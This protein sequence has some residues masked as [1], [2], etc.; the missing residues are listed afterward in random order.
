MKKIS[1]ILA[2]LILVLL[3]FSGCKNFV[4]QNV[5][6]KKGYVYFNIKDA[7]NS[8]A[9]IATASYDWNNFTYRLYAKVGGSSERKVIVPKDNSYATK[10]EIFTGHELALTSYVFT[11]EAYD[12]NKSLVFQSADVP[13]DLSNG[14]STVSFI[15]YPAGTKTGSALITL[16]FP[17]GEDVKSVSCCT[18][19][20]KTNA[21]S[22]KK[23]VSV[24]STSG[25]YNVVEY[26]I[27]DLTPGYDTVAV[28][29]LNDVNGTCIAS[30]ME[31]LVIVGGLQSTSEIVLSANDYRKYDVQM[32]LKLEGN[33]WGDSKKQLILVPQEDINDPN[34]RT[35]FLSEVKATATFT[36]NIAD[37]PYYIYVKDLS[38]NK[39]DDQPAYGYNTMVEY[40]P[41]VNGLIS[42]YEMN[43]VTL[44]AR[45]LNYNYV[46]GGI[47][48]GQDSDGNDMYYVAK[49]QSLTVGINI[50]EGYSNTSVNIEGKSYQNNSNV[51]IGP[52]TSSK[53]VSVLGVS[54]Q[55]YN[56][57]Y[58]MG[59]GSQKDTSKFKTS[60]TVEDTVDL[61]GIAAVQGPVENK[62]LDGWIDAQ[63]N[64]L[65]TIS[66]GTTG[67]KLFTA[68]YKTI[69]I[70]LTNNPS[71]KLPDD[72]EAGSFD[73]F[74]IYPSICASGFSMIVKWQNDDPSTNV[75]EVW[76]DMNG[77]GA[78]DVDDGDYRVTGSANPKTEDFTGYILK[79]EKPNSSDKP[80][81]NFTFSI[82]GGH[83][84]AIEGLGAD[85]ANIS[86]VNI[87]GTNT[88]I[89]GTVKG[90]KTGVN[91]PTF[92]NE[93]INIAGQL[94]GEYELTILSKNSYYSR[95][96]FIDV[97]KIDDKTWVELGKVTC[98]YVGTD[99][100]KVEFEKEIELELRD[101]T[102]N[103]T[104]YLYIRNPE[105]I[106][107]PSEELS[108]PGENVPGG[109]LWITEPDGNISKTEFTLGDTTV[110]NKAC[111]VFSILVENGSMKLS[112]TQM[113][114]NAGAYIST[115][116]LGKYKTKVNNQSYTENL[117]TTDTYTYIHMMSEEN[118]LTPFS[119]TEFLK[120]IHFIKNSESAKIKIKLNLEAVDYAD[121]AAMVQEATANTGNSKAF[122][123][124]DGSFYLGVRSTAT[125]G[126]CTW[127]EAYNGAKQIVFNGMRGYLINITSDVENDYIFNR[128]GLGKAWT[129]GARYD[130]VEDHNND[131]SFKCHLDETYH[132]V[133]DS[134]SRTSP[135]TA[136]RIDT[137]HYRWQCGPEAGN[138]I[139]TGTIPYNTAAISV[140]EPTKITSAKYGSSYSGYANKTVD[141]LDA[142]KVKIGTAVTGTSGGSMTKGY[143]L[144]ITSSNYTGEPKYIGYCTTGTGSYTGK[145]NIMYANWAS[146]EPNDSFAS[147]TSEEC[148]H[149][150]T[151]GK[152]ND[153]NWDR[154]GGD[155]TV[156]SYIVEF[157]PYETVYGKSK[158]TKGSIKQEASY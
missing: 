69:E 81:S 9:R 86:T 35:I 27:S 14:T 158:A 54:C 33:Q 80:A 61:P 149:F 40:Q 142:N 60:Y 154:Y 45:G 101:D 13:V 32:P 2:G 20:I 92:K 134:P 114:N 15:M 136:F 117:T 8:G 76:L 115:S 39:L 99:T 55:I 12:S 111:S 49:N 140:F 26:A 151:D 112:E 106:G 144:T 7:D 58:D 156:T 78:I 145:K 10:S 127:I 24:F 34:P 105:E 135:G 28:F 41:S 75:T 47:Y 91:L 18:Q 79:A 102:R 46:S 16:K 29:Y 157:S 123:Y 17:K 6:A 38:D 64:R 82:Y 122:S 95:K 131:G 125:N 129:G 148:I 30:R 93:C 108:V 110:I 72:A 109:V 51:V 56:I 141:L 52:V 128:M 19:N 150:K 133:Y 90:R 31:S 126:G 118:S 1:S 103:N 63:G 71:E 152:W 65:S 121:I 59:G 53:M 139:S 100:S 130:S 5:D 84:A 124:Y 50:K 57:R 37:I 73:D 68:C 137:P 42:N 116:N 94:S 74:T 77:N 97:V 89:G 25:D 43:T 83:L 21:E 143:T 70:G 153:F 23:T 147:G 67:D 3:T 44:P 48:G 119:A 132:V 96:P 4:T 113:K 155:D 98:L 88:V 104:H 66:K 85:A 11:L 120:T 62:V 146:G 36:G 87:Q 107:L 22:N 138:I